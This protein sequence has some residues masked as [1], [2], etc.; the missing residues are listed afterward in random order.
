MKRPVFIS[1]PRRWLQETD[2]TCWF[3]LQCMWI[4]ENCLCNLLVIKCTL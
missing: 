4:S 2:E 1:D 3:S